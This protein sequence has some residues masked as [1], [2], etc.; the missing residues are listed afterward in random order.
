MAP[1][2]ENVQ[3]QSIV[4]YDIGTGSATAASNVV[5]TF[6]AGPRIRLG[7][8][9]S[10]TETT[11]G[12][13]VVYTVTAFNDG[14]LAGELTAG[15]SIPPGSAFV[16]GSV[17]LGGVP[18]P[19][20]DPSQGIY[21]GLIEP[22]KSASFSY[23]VL[24]GASVPSGVLINEAYGSA[25]FR[26]PSGRVLTVDAEPASLRIPVRTASALAR[27]SASESVVAP[28]D[29]VEYVLVINND[30]A[31]GLSGMTASFILP[32]G[33][34]F[35][36]GSVN[37]NGSFLP[38][39]NSLIGIPVGLLG[40]GADIGVSFAVRVISS[41]ASG[42]P[43]V[44]LVRYIVGSQ[45]ETTPSNA[46]ELQVTSDPPI[47][48]KSVDTQQ[49]SPGDILSYVVTASVPTGPPQDAVLMDSLPAGL[50]YVPNSLLIN[51]QPSL[52]QN[53]AEGVSLGPVSGISPATVFFR[54][55]VLPIQGQPLSQLFNVQ[56]SA[57]VRFTG[58]EGIITTVETEPVLTI[59]SSAAFRVS[60]QP[61]V[62]VSEPGETVWITITVTAVG[63]QPAE[64][65]LSGFVPEGMM[66]LPD[67]LTVD[68]VQISIQDGLL[69]LGL[70]APGS[71]ILIRFAGLIAPN[72]A[73]DEMIGTAA[74]S[75]RY[76][77][78]DRTY[79]GLS[80]AARYTIA[81]EG[82]VE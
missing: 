58:Q 23:Q 31:V 79:R 14:N 13:V 37:V 76:T 28:G 54:A 6:V 70:L 67:T 50:R 38:D 33:L 62:Y 11:A 80:F 39:A 40:A 29:I 10:V 81:V 44:A 43:T 53:L 4:Q 21:L 49:A 17:T 32:P 20:A 5:T 26:T 77:I 68:G 42:L 66:L 56:N 18:L 34:E 82:H 78:E 69:P 52:S 51:G 35:I 1:P 64:G 57:V 16:P 3:N 8:T 48:T 65:F 55:E 30:G 59:I 41:A 36:A 71:V 45:E 61:D 72:Y 24:V 74:L 27:L 15:S 25:L 19:G 9:A 60:A 22:G 63:S 46:V 47:V 7:L 12:S 75:W 2:Y 73:G